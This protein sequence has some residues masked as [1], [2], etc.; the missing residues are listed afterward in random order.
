[1]AA[2]VGNDRPRPAPE[3]QQRPN[4]KDRKRLAPELQGCSRETSLYLAERDGMQ[5]FYCRRPFDRLAEVTKDHYVPK[6][7]WACNLPANLVLACEPCNVAKG[8]RLT[9]SM[10]AVLLA[11]AERWE[12]AA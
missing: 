10:A 5:C 1:M 8:D 2:T 9:W 6:S 12:V 4:K 11:H 7:L 3:P